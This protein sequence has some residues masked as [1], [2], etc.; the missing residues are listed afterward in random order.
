MSKG[1]YGEL[2]RATIPKFRDLIA[3]VPQSEKKSIINRF[4]NRVK[5]LGDVY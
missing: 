1:A 4:E 2:L 3:D 5:V